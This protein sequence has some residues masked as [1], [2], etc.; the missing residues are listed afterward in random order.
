MN[1]YTFVGRAAV[2]GT[3]VLCAYACTALLLA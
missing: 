2:I 1:W 3:A